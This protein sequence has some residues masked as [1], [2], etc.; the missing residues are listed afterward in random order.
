[1]PKRKKVTLQDIAKK[2][3]FSIAT[4]SHYINKTRKIEEST[5]EV[6]LNAIKDLGYPLPATR[7]YTAGSLTIGIIISDIRVDYFS[8]IV[9]AAEDY[10][11][12][13]SINII[14]MDS[15]E[16]PK[17][18][19]MC[20]KTMMKLGVAGII[21]APSDTKANFNYCNSFP[22]VQID[23]MVDNTPFD[24]IGIDNLTSTYIM[25]KKLINANHNKIGFI[26]FPQDNYCARERARGYK[27]SMIENNIYDE[28]LFLEIPYDATSTEHNIT[29]WLRQHEEITSLICISTNICSEALDSL[30][31][32]KN[33]ANITKICTFDNNKWLDHLSVPIDS[34]VQPTASIAST[35]IEML[36]MQ[37]SNGIQQC[38]AKKIFLNSEIM[39]RK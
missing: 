35:A 36:I 32:L 26:T 21:L 27:L 13:K 10:A 34:I 7:N 24:F 29:N 14:F 28:N 18:E 9:R 25:T 38:E 16:N 6:I 30:E 23:R 11:Y 33:K 37:I 20:I 12:D 3:G 39:E 4:I 15:E 31:Y 17:K 2:T 19:K 1:M 8:E 22:I 5:Q